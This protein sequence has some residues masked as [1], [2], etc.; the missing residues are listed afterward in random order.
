M[1]INKI[2]KYNKIKINDQDFKFKSNNN[3]NNNDIFSSL[4]ARWHQNIDTS[5][6]DKVERSLK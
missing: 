6:R 1:N 4:K 3:N 5:N 2:N